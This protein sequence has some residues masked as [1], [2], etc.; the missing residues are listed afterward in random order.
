M[1]VTFLGFSSCNTDVSKTNA[2]KHIFPQSENN[3]RKKKG[4]KKIPFIQFSFRSFSTFA[5]E[6]VATVTAYVTRRLFFGS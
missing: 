6:G 3:K 2:P 5:D 1:A 4:Q